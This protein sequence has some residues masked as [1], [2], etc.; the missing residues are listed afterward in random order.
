MV[1]WLGFEAVESAVGKVLLL[2]L[3][4][5]WLPAPPKMVRLGEISCRFYLLPSG[6]FRL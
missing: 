2:S 3:I 1:E 6:S 4:H 5:S